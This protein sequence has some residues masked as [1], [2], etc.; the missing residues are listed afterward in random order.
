[1]KPCLSGAEVQAILVVL[2]PP[3]PGAES[4]KYEGLRPFLS[5]EQMYEC[6]NGRI[7][8]SYSLE[9]AGDL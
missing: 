9:L 6:V 1:M 2:A 5:H 8:H 7:D 4:G 3:A